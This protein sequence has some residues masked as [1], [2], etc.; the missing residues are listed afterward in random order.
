VNSGANSREI[1]FT[2]APNPAQEAFHRSPAYMRWIYGGSGGGKTR[3][4]CMEALALALQYPDNMLV[5]AR[6]TLVDLKRTTKITLLEDCIPPEAW[7]CPGWQW[8]EGDQELTL[9]S[10]GGGKSHIILMGLDEPGRLGSLNLGGFVIDECHQLR[11]PAPICRAFQRQMRRKGVR[12]CGIFSGH[13]NGKDWFYRRFI[14]SPRAGWEAFRVN[15]FDNQANLPEGF[16]EQLIEDFPPEYAKRFIYGEFLDFAGSVFSEFDEARHVVEPFAIPRHWTRYRGMDYGIAEPT[17]CLWAA[18]DEQGAVYLYDEYYVTNTP[19]LQQVDAI[20]GK[21]GKDEVIATLLDGRSAGLR[22]Q[23]QIGLI[24]VAQ[25]YREAGLPVIP[26]ATG[27]EAD[28]EAGILRIKGLLAGD[29]LKIFRQGFVGDRRC[30]CP[31]L[32]RE[33]RGLNYTA[34]EEGQPILDKFTGEDHC[35]DA[36]R[37]V[38]T[39]HYGNSVV[40]GR[41]EP[42]PHTVEWD[43]QRELNPAGEEEW[44]WEGG[45]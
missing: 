8:R 27:K 4:A 18:V 42:R 1:R 36:L 23:T 31:N 14:E 29:K 5:I 32:V 43:I 2:Y 7:E 22:Q 34:R 10:A 6:D 28:V 25:Q 16:I 11:D 37:Y 21:S 24:S 33:M 40:G 30:G 44:D 41:K 17:V 35:L 38:V 9:P 13:P 12:R 3:A 45:A 26:S 15:P 19:I 39:R 20:V